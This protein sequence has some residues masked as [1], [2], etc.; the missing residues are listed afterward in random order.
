[1]SFLHVPT[2][3]YHFGTIIT[4]QTS[5]CPNVVAYVPPGSPETTINS[6]LRKSMC[7]LS[8]SGSGINNVIASL[9]A[10]DPSREYQIEIILRI[11]IGYDAR[12]R[13]VEL[14]ND[15][16][17]LWLIAC[18]NEIIRNYAVRTRCLRLIADKARQS[19]ES[20]DCSDHMK[21]STYQQPHRAWESNHWEALL[22][23]LRLIVN[24]TSKENLKPRKITNK[25]K[26][27]QC[28]MQKSQH[29]QIDLNRRI[30]NMNKEKEH[31]ICCIQEP[32][33]V[34]SK[35]ISQPNTVQRFGKSVN[36]RT[37]IYTDVNTSAWF[38]EAL[39]TKDITAIQVCIQKQQVLVVSAYLDSADSAVWSREM[40]KVVEYADG[41]NL[42]LI[43]CMDSNCHSTLFGPDNNTR[44]KKF[45]EAVAGHNLVVENIGHVPTFHGGRARTCIDVTLTKKLHSTVLGWSVNTDYN[46]SDHNTI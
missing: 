1:M 7:H 9:L 35:L 15:I 21:L 20:N 41:K 10:T 30:S 25:I 5:F 23:Y 26:F 46:G 27:L 36:P 28:N 34:R 43:I 29:A 18:R 44:G 45:E 4:C 2:N 24:K 38:L 40:D 33:S 8:V 42:G 19:N 22:Q 32:C 37:C 6:R 31:F 11:S 13:Y 3:M 14:L 16:T 12:I 17:E 39:S